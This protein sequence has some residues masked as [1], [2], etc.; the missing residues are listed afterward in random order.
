MGQSK[1]VIL[2]PLNDPLENKEELMEE[3][4][5]RRKALN[6]WEDFVMVDN[7]DD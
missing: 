4:I 1:I 6:A 7:E 5:E 3:A 2:E